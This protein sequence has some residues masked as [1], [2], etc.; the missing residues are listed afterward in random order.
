MKDWCLD[1][2]NVY[3]KDSGPEI[4][5]TSISDH[6]DTWP[7]KRTNWNLPLK[8]LLISS[9]VYLRFQENKLYKL[10]PHARHNQK[11]LIY[12]KIQLQLQVMDSNQML[13]IYYEL[14]KEVDSQKSH[15]A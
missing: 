4:K 10:I 2:L 14:L 6:E 8:K 7:F 11:L 3:K 5:Y 15:L 12:L 13:N 1:Q 9:E